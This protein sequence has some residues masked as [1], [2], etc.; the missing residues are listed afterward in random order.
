MAAINPWAS[1]GALMDQSWGMTAV[2]PWA[3]WALC[4]QE[5]AWHMEGSPE[6]GRRAA[7]L[8]AAQE[9]VR[10]GCPFLKG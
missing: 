7:G 10:W 6:E 5:P 3:S 1:W 8:P 4:P 2:D 9:Q